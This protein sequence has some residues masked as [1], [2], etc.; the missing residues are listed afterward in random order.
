MSPGVLRSIGM[1]SVEP[2]SP[3]TMPHPRE[4]VKPRSQS[5]GLRGGGS[6][7]VE[8]DGRARR[9]PAP[10][11]RPVPDRALAARGVSVHRRAATPRP[12]EAVRPPLTAPHC[13][14][15]RPGHR[16]PGHLRAEFL[17]ADDGDLALLHGPLSEGLPSLSGALAR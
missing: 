15:A 7:M 9:A 2:H 17:R 11:E 3:G 6:D 14:G 8:P 16:L 5:S 1:P 4:D 10:P 13:L 12:P